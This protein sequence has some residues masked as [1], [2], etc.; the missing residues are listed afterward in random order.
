MCAFLY[1]LRC[2]HSH[3]NLSHVMYKLCSSFW[4]P[5]NFKYVR[6]RLWL[7]GHWCGVFMRLDWRC[8]YRSTRQKG[9]TCTGE[10]VPTQRLRN[11]M[12]GSFLMAERWF[13]RR[14]SQ[15]HNHYL[16]HR[17]RRYGRNE[18]GPLFIC[19]IIKAIKPASIVA[20]E[21]K[22]RNA[23]EGPLDV[24]GSASTTGKDKEGK[25]RGQ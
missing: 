5:S 15:Q 20:S 24:I 11:T 14:S 12:V 23:R 13:R 19:D 7:T 2:I 8:R 16:S 22:R 10:W 3:E 25:G 17:R 21:F 1:K 18:R 9:C 4:L 6:S